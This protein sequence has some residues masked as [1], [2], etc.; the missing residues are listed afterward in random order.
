M[1]KVK[2]SKS[3]ECSGERQTSFGTL[4]FDENGISQ[5]IES[6]V[7][8]ALTDAS[9]SLYLVGEED[10]AAE[11]EAE[12][13]RIAAEKEAEKEAE[14][15][16]IAAEKEAE[17]ARIAAE[18]GSQDDDK[19]SKE[20]LSKMGMGDLREILIEAGIAQEEIDKFKG[21]DTK[22]ALVNFVYEK[23]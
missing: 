12:N 19:I 5:E 1:S 14:N 23:Q 7:A 10:V 4:K 6:E 13:A 9:P 8:T 22:D 20:V 18:N 2:T 15:A 16:R 17:N 11:K 3:W 21:K